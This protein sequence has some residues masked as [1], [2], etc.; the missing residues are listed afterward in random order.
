MNELIKTISQ[1]DRD[2]ADKF[3]SE[4][5]AQPTELTIK[6]MHGLGEAE[7]YLKKYA[8][9]SQEYQE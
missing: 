8:P 9:Q 3:V 4:W 1:A 6:A 5:K 7:D 2:K